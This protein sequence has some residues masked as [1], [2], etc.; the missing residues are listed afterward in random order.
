MTEA[1]QPEGVG[2]SPAELRRTL[3][4][5]FVTVM[6]T[7]TINDW[8]IELLRPRNSDDLISEADFVLDERLPYWADLWPSSRILAT[9]LLEVVPRRA[10]AGRNSSSSGADSDW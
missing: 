5:Q 1:R 9:Y 2:E 7:V 6:D 8:A 4:R 3:T 10:R